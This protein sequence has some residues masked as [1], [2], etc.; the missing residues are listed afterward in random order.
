[1]HRSLLIALF[2][3]ATLIACSKTEQPA[4]VVEQSPVAEVAQSPVADAAQSPAAETAQSPAADQS[5]AK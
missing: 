3:A 1:M 5:A 2:A 4:P